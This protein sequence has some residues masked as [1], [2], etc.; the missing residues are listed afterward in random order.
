ML[1]HTLECN[2]VT[3]FIFN[4]DY[5]HNIIVIIQLLQIKP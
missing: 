2:V 4:V 5:H 1:K 3:L